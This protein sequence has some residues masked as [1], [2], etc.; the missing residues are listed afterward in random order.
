MRLCTK[1]C[2]FATNFILAVKIPFKKYKGVYFMRGGMKKV[3]KN[4]FFI[5]CPCC[6][7][8][9][10]CKQDNRNSYEKISQPKITH[11]TRAACTGCLHYNKVYTT[12]YG[13]KLVKYQG[14]KILNGPNKINIYQNNASI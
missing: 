13:I 2:Y 5:C 14:V 6:Q 11:C 3:N 8:T 7:G 4:I 10:Q 1:I 9:C 12:K